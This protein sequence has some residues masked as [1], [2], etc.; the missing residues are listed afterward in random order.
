MSTTYLAWANI[1][2]CTSRYG[3]YI[4]DITNS[5]ECLFSV[6]VK[7]WIRYSFFLFGNISNTFLCIGS[8]NI[9]AYLPSLVSALNSS[10]DMTLGKLTTCLGIADA[11]FNNSFST[12]KLDTLFFFRNIFKW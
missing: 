3:S 5:T 10:N 9:K 11:I 12:I 7:Y 4:S 1:T 2:F 8:F 6:C